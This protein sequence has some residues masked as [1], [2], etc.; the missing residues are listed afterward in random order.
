MSKLRKRTA[1]QSLRGLA[2]DVGLDMQKGPTDM[3]REAFETL[4]K[5]ALAMYSTA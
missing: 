4:Q 3:T 2:L 1:V 5:E